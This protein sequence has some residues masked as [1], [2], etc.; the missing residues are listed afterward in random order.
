MVAAVTE[1]G[2]KTEKERREIK[3]TTQTRIDLGFSLGALKAER[4][5]E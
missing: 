2:P 4:D 1:S 3:P 5:A